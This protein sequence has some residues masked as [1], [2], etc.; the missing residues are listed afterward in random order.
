[1]R[2]SIL[3]LAAFATIAMLIAVLAVVKY[4]ESMTVAFLPVVVVFIMLA[5]PLV[6]RSSKHEYGGTSNRSRTGLKWLFVPFAIGVLGALLMALREGWDVG[7]TIGAIFF[8]V[9][10]FLIM[11]E[12]RRRRRA[13][14][15]R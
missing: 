6:W 2:K 8:G 3:F 9:F 7:D 4:S 14:D 5:V 13:T 12:M 15:S 1:M 11:F 10:A